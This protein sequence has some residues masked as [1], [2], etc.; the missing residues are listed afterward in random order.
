M[1]YP[2]SYGREDKE[3]VKRQKEK[4]IWDLSSVALA[5]ED[6]FRVRFGRLLGNDVFGSW[7]FLTL[8]DIKGYRVAFFEGFVSFG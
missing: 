8:D 7:A 1:L 2:L 3:N 6:L 5:K 4:R